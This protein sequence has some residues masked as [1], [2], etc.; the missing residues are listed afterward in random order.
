[1]AGTARQL[2]HLVGHH[3][4]A[5]ALLAGSGRLYGGVESQQ[6]GLIRDGADDGGH[7]PYL[8]HPLLEPIDLMGGL[9]HLGGE[10]LDAVHAGVDVFVAE[11]G[12]A[13]GVL[14]VAGRVL[15]V[16]RHI[17]DG[18]AH[19]VHGSGELG[20]LI[21][22]TVDRLIGLLGGGGDAQ[23]GIRHV[24]G[25]LARLQQGAAN[26][27]QSLIGTA[28]DGPQLILAMHG[29]AD[30]QI[31]G[32][33]LSHG[34]VDLRQR[35]DDGAADGHPQPPHQQ[36]HQQGGAPHQLVLGPDGGLYVLQQ[37]AGAQDPAPGLVTGH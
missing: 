22:L 11:S 4:E 37:E 12:L 30:H 9:L 31:P 16:T 26:G 24:A 8:H 13:G 25:P 18:G 33:H 17:R 27:V 10:C 21:P 1:M 34:P 5:A 7:L 3:G 20:Q 36:D 35:V 23:G 14:G 19:L 15:G 2:A 6:V 29:Y 32:R 28:G